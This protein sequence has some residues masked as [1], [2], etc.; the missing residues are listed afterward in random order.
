LDVEDPGV[1][2]DVDTADDL[3]HL[4]TVAVRED[5]PSEQQ[6]VT[7]LQEHGASPELVA[8]SKAVGAVAIAIGA[9]I[10]EQN[11]CLCLPLLAAG[12]L[13]H[14]I[15]RSQPGHG[16]AG[17]RL[18]VRLGYPR[19]APVVRPHM[20]L[21]RDA[22]GDIGEA[23]IVYLADKLVEGARFVGLEARFETRLAQCSDD[24][25]RRDA[26]LARKT[27]GSSSPG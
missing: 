9:A 13:L 24:S 8:H 20:R 26:V 12:A 7:L 6:C 15:A 27:E 16:E 21:G 2:L 14:D 1:L 19:L 11:H 10:Q 5:L 3:Q 25:G 18:L 23:Q 4:R 17:A 22:E